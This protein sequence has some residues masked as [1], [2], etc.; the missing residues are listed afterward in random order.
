[1]SSRLTRDYGALGVPTNVV[2]IMLPTGDIRNRSTSVHTRVTLPP[3]KVAVAV[4]Q[5]HVRF[6]HVHVIV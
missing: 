1:M 6:V 3:C 5:M 2:G 4:R